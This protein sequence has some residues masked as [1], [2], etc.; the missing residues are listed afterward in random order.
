[1]LFAAG[2]PV[3][4]DL[5]VEAV[6]WAAQQLLTID[7]G[8]RRGLPCSL[9]L[10]S[11]AD[12][13][14]F[15]DDLE[16]AEQL[17][18]QVIA[19]SLTWVQSARRHIRTQL[20]SLGRDQLGAEV[21]SP[22]CQLAKFAIAG[23]RD[24]PDTNEEDL[25]GLLAD[26]DQLIR[27]TGLGT[28]ADHAAADI[29]DVLPAI[30]PRAPLQASTFLTPSEAQALPSMRAVLLDVGEQVATGHTRL[31]RGTGWL[32]PARAAMQR[33]SA[34]ERRRCPLR[35]RFVGRAFGRHV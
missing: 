21:S 4:D 26:A 11:P 29:T 14:R 8:I 7:C 18:R 24:D 6:R 15:G 16:V 20:P 5:L 34:A 32:V 25:A 33:S 30:T 31:P 27:A 28:V 12:I 1:V 19:G 22:A 10:P 9:S 2:L 17:A 13:E 35:S 3:S 23:V